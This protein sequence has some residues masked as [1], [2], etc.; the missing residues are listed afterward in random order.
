[1]TGHGDSS[2]E[3]P[4][5]QHRHDHL[6]GALDPVI[7]TTARGVRALKWSFVILLA[8]AL[9]QVVIAAISGLGAVALYLLV[10]PVYW[11]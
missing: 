6:H 4:L 9:F 5:D 7:L 11:D 1:M 8:T 2:Q 3:P 10:L